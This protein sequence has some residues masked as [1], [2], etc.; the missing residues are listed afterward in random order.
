MN[1]ERSCYVCKKNWVC[2]I[3]RDFSKII[4]DNVIL[5]RPRIKGAKAPSNS[6]QIFNAI[7][8]CCLAIKKNV[9]G[10]ISRTLGW[11][12]ILMNCPYCGHDKSRVLDVQKEDKVNN[13]VLICKKC[14]RAFNTTETVDINESSG[15]TN[16]Q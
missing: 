15:F 12:K 5:E 3:R 10:R 11:Y 7:A 6:K 4:E 8:N 2:A 1:L 16:Q 14:Q 9:K 13:R